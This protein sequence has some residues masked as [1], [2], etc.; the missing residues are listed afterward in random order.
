VRKFII[1]ALAIIMALGLVG[2][3]TLAYFVDTET[4]AGNSFTAGTLDL[5]ISDDDEGYGD[6]VTGTWTMTNM[7][8]GVT[9]ALN[10]VSLQ[11]SGNIGTNHV[12]LGFNH[13][14]DEQTAPPGVNPVESDTNPVSVAADLAEWLEITQMTYTGGGAWYDWVADFTPF[15]INEDPNGNGFF[16]LDDVSGPTYSAEGGLLDNLNPPPA[17]NGGTRT[18]N[19]KLKFNAGA[20]NDIQGDE[21]TTTVSFTLNQDAS[22]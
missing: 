6:G 11:N 5:V 4:S 16:D 2:A 22:Q 12:E 7:A 21:L 20:T 1:S 17:N 9:Q 15:D 13:T 18:F 19:L 8:P 14:I 3:G 10:S